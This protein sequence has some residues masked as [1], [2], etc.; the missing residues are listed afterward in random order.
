MPSV[1][2]YRF[3]T[4]ED[5]N[6]GQSIGI[7]N[8]LQYLGQSNSKETLDV[9]LQKDPAIPDFVLTPAG[10]LPPKPDQ[11]GSSSGAGSS[12]SSSSATAVPSL[13]TKSAAGSSPPKATAGNT[14]RT[15]SPSSTQHQP[16][17]QVLLPFLVWPIIDDLGD[18]DDRP[19]LTRAKLKLNEVYNDI[20]T[21]HSPKLQNYG[22]KK[23][24]AASFDPNLLTSE[25][26][27]TVDGVLQSIEAEKDSL[28]DDQMTTIKG[29]VGHCE[30]L[31]EWFTPS[32]VSL[33]LSP[34][35]TFGYLTFH[36]SAT[37]RPSEVASHNSVTLYWNLVGFIVN[38]SNCLP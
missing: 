31:L 22:E 32:D 12:P 18:E 36:L 10:A 37:E 19:R 33:P 15:V 7:L 26:V 30:S 9:W 27:H 8:W 21:R 4:S 23:Y 3:Y 34:V 24:L 13:A 25:P 29:F 38:V 6:D 2:N 17:S 35:V 20:V 11:T 5:P 16:V 14:P 1:A 28:D